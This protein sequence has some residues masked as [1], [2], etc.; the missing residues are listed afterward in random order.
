MSFKLEIEHNVELPNCGGQ[1]GA[2]KSV[3]SETLS[4]MRIG[5]SF[6][7]EANRRDICS[8]EAK[9]LGLKITSRAIPGDLKKVRVWVVESQRAYVAP[10][11]AIVQPPTPK[12][13]EEDQADVNRVHD[14]SEAMPS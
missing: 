4:Q 7:I 14:V 11:T 1:L 12:P 13:V 8:K 5:D 3:I 10:P 6:R 9:A 2:I